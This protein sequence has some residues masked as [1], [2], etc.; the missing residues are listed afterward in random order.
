MKKE[1]LNGIQEIRINDY[2]QYDSEKCNNGGA[3]GFWTKYDR[4]PNG[5]FEIS[6]GTTADFE[7]CPVCGCFN[8]HYDPEYDSEYSCGDFEIITETELL[9][10]INN[11]KETEDFFID[12]YMETETEI[13]SE[14]DYE[15]FSNYPDWIEE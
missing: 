12:F 14:D 9:E 11:F 13:I 6:Y 7:F 4:L 15:E 3:Y 8:D 5:K 1:N 2:S 10:I